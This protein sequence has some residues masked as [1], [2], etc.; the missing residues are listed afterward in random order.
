MPAI[1]ESTVTA[2]CLSSTS[3]TEFGG[4]AAGVCG[5]ENVYAEKAD[6]GRQAPDAQE[7]THH[8]ALRRPI[9]EG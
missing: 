5:R 7:A 2:G 3:S 1:D 6:T 4:H 9:A 8:K